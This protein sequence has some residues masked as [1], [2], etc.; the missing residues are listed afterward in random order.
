MGKER[1]M[2]WRSRARAGTRAPL[3]G[4]RER[5]SIVAPHSYSFHFN[6]PDKRQE[7]TGSS[8]NVYF[9][10]KIVFHL[11]YPTSFAV[12]IP[13]FCY[14]HLELM[15]VRALNTWSERHP[16]DAKYLCALHKLPQLGD[17]LV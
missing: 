10:T 16:T 17:D 12:R 14:M 13:R 5:K 6:F 3:T 8:R 15:P 2:W 11:R 7:K 4:A 9:Y 1:R